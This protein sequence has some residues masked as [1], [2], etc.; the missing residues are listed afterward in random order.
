MKKVLFALAGFL[1]AVGVA[2][3]QEDGPKLAKSAGKALA[4]YNQDP[5]GNGSKLNEAVTKIEQALQTPE[6]QAQASAWLVK[7]DV[8]STRLQNEMAMKSINPTAKLSGDND[9]L[10]AI[11]AYKSALEIPTAKNTKKSRLLTVLPLCSLR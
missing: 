4:A 3:A 1:L 7:G 10:V 8:Y 6:A 5:A 11:Y 9:A 2:Q